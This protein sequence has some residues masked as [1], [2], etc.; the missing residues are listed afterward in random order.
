[1]GQ[2][3]EMTF[4]GVSI[5]A[6]NV[7]AEARF[8]SDLLGWSAQP[9]PDGSVT[10]VP[11][12]GSAYVISIQPADTAK[13][14]PNKIHFDLTSDSPESMA[15]GVQRGLDAGGRLIDI[16]Q[17]AEEGPRSSRRPRGQRTVHHRTRQPI[18]RRYGDDRRHQLRRNAGLGRLLESGAGLAAGVGPGS[19]DG[20]PVT[21]RRFEDHLE[22]TAADAALRA[23]PAP[24]HAGYGGPGPGA[25]STER[26]GCHRDRRHHDAR[27]GR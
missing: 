13:V 16:G 10:L 24:T 5:D 14:G 15:A 11:S 3:H 23:R 2:Q 7:A 20:D 19:G 4:R 18:P 26:A 12:D 22:R 17:T 6:A 21:G 8:W 27:S 1:M 25:H 9:A